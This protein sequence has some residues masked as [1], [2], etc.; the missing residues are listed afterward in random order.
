MKTFNVILGI[1]I[2]VMLTSFYFKEC[3][4]Q[5]TSVTKTDTTNVSVK[6]SV[7][8]KPEPK[9]VDTPDFLIDHS[10]IAASNAK[11]SQ[12]VYEPIVQKRGWLKRVFSHDSEVVYKGA[13]QMSATSF[14][15]TAAIFK[16]YYSVKHYSDTFNFKYGKTIINET[17]TQN[18]IE[19]RSVSYDYLIPIET[20]T[21][22]VTPKPLNRF[23]AGFDL[24]YVLGVNLMLETKSGNLYGLHT[25][26]GFHGALLMVSYDKTIFK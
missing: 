17:V 26:V 1:I 18:K 11:K 6:G 8:E 21:T 4:Q 22:R 20:K 10:H 13:T 12:T 2:G 9:E 19:T 24:G 16:D 7:N 25:D 3:V 5:Y 23:Y 14:A 15:D